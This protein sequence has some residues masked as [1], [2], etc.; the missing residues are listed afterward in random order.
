MAPGTGREDPHGEGG[1]TGTKTTRDTRHWGGRPTEKTGGRWGEGSRRGG[2]CA[3]SGASGPEH[4]PTQSREHQRQ[5]PATGNAPAQAPP[6]GEKNPAS[7]PRGPPNPPCPPPLPPPPGAYLHITHTRRSGARRWTG[8][9]RP[10]RPWRLYAAAAA[11]PPRSSLPIRSRQGGGEGAAPP[12][13]PTGRTYV[14]WPG[15]APS[16]PSP[17]PPDARRPNG[18][19][20][21]IPRRAGE[22]GGGWGRHTSGRRVPRPSS[23]KHPTVRP[24]RRRVGGGEGGGGRKE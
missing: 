3:G 14:T 8:R 20:V 1:N 22:E 4:P 9:P 2:A 24:E 12:Q 21:P 7:K 6:E 11:R 13:P 19:P 18:C 5:R 15:R 10:Q 16:R 23:A 17:P